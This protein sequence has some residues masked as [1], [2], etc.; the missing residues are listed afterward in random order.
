[1]SLSLVSKWSLL[2]GLL[3]GGV[4]V[5]ACAAARDGDHV[6]AV[7]AVSAGL[8]LLVGWIFTRDDRRALRRLAAAFEQ[9]RSGRYPA[10]LPAV[11]AREVQGLCET[12][13]RAAEELE[14]LSRAK[15]EQNEQLN[16]L[17]KLKSDFLSIVSHDLR[18]P[19]TS[20]KF[21]TEL[22]LDGVGRM[23]AGDERQFLQI[24]NAECDRLSRLIDDLLDLRMIDGDHYRRNAK[25]QDLREPILHA[26]KTFEGAAQAKRITLGCRLP[27]SLP[28]V[29]ADR[30]RI[31]QVV[32]NLLSNAIKFTPEGGR[33][34]VI[35]SADDSEV[36]LEVRDTG[37]GIHRDDWAAIFDRFTQLAD[38]Q[39]RQAGG[40]GLGLHIVKQIVEAHGGRVWVD[41]EPGKGS[42]F[43]VSLPVERRRARWVPEPAA[44]GGGPNRVL[45]CD[46]DPEL[47]AR[48]G[49]V[50]QAEGFEP[51]YCHSGHQVL[52][53]A[54]RWRPA[55]ILMDLLLPDI[56]GL[57]VLRM[58]NSQQTTKDIPVLVHTYA[59]NADAALDAGAVGY[60]TKPACKDELVL[61]V[62]AYAARRGGR[63]QTVLIAHRD[64][65]VRDELSYHMRR[66]GYLCVVESC[67]DGALQKARQVRPHVVLIDL[68]LDGA[69]RWDL[70]DRM[71]AVLPDR[72]TPIVLV[73]PGLSRRVLK[74]ARQFDLLR[75]VEQR[76]PGSELVRLLEEMLAEAAR[77]ET[78]A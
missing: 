28:K 10:R 2:G 36:R 21:Y 9:L 1:M 71:R 14:A 68:R 24:M 42:R 77:C 15:D 51:I 70:I 35:V 32:S 75:V 60:L 43:Y 72:A 25:R 44:S 45:V 37:I 6:L 52:A 76:V 49:Q 39:T 56:D 67:L 11:G 73:V 20:L 57:D 59:E 34:D 17:N 4:A 33:V 63:R 55:L 46:A 38:P 26:V 7:V 16:R 69:E 50:L 48:I 29:L 65:R 19:L 13:N 12:F 54:G 5:F 23:P 8:G 53:L 27:E 18:T 66:A 22:L 62:R 78:A 74:R 31:I 61:C 47:V 40:A 41:S 64:P 58:L 30:D 3:A